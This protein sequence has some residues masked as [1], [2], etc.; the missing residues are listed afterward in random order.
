MQIQK[1]Y[2]KVNPMLIYGEVEDM[3][4]RYGGTVDKDKSYKEYNPGGGGL[5]ASIVATFAVEVAKSMSILGTR[6]KIVQKEA[7]NARIFGKSEGEI[8][9]MIFIDEESI[10]LTKA[11]AMEADLEFL[12]KSYESTT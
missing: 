12:T 8:K 2:D 9:L 10:P 7:F 3:V 4:K 5:K 1:T 11:K 6:K